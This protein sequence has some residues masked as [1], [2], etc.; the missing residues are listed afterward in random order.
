MRSLRQH[1]RLIPFLFCL[2]SATAQADEPASKLVALW[3]SGPM[4]VRLAFEKGVD[5]AQAKAME[6]RTIDFHARTKSTAPG[7]RQGSI[8]IAAARLSDDG[9][10]VILATD[11][12]PIDG[13]YALSE[14]PLSQPLTYSLRGV[15]AAWTPQNGGQ[16]WTGWWPSLDPEIVRLSLAQSAEHARELA[17]LN[18][19]GR[20]ELRTF[21]ELPPGASTLRLTSKAPFE[22]SVNFE[23]VKPQPVEDGFQAEIAVEATAEPI[24]CSLSLPTGAPA[25]FVD[26]AGHGSS[27]VKRRIQ[28][29]CRLRIRPALGSHAASHGRRTTKAP[30]RPRGW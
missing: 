27:W 25:T 1:R 14:T 4:E 2:S 24:E 9:R 15:E 21:L 23:A 11:P 7:P 3:P 28:A 19:P 26:L 20:L 16:A 29:T 6:G 8:R 13:L 22:A 10:I 17:N 18:Q 30:L 5:P 12:H